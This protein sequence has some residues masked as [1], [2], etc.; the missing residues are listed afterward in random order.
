MRLMQTREIEMYHLGN[1][2]DILFR[3]NVEYKNTMKYFFVAA[4]F[5]YR[6]TAAKR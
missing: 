2:N 4:I 3:T 1:G 5:V 6:N